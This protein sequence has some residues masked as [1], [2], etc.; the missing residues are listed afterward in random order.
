MYETVELRIDGRRAYWRVGDLCSLTGPNDNTGG[1]P[2]EYDRRCVSC[3]LGHGHSL[4][5][6][7]QNLDEIVQLG[8]RIE[9]LI[10]N[11]WS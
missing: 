2:Y 6:H 7:H 1:M 9:R 5:Y 10:S 8:D 4:Q 3:Y 11:I